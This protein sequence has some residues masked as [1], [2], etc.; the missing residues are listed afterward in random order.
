MTNEGTRRAEVIGDLRD[1]PQRWWLMVL[2]IVGMVLCYVQRGA[3]S[4]A[5]PSMMKELRLT[6]AEMGLLLSAFFLS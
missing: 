3:L 4:V 2:L 1:S 5:A 6:E